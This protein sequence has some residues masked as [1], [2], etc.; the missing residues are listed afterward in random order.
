MKLRE[1]EA[2][3]ILEEVKLNIKSGI[4][5]ASLQSEDAL[6]YG[7]DGLTPKREPIVSLLRSIQAL[8]AE[9]LDVG[10]EFFSISSVFQKPSLIKEISDLLGL[11]K[12][13]N[14]LLRWE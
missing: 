13:T 9:G 14:Q 4:N 2:K 5:G 1:H 11:A 6:L 7:S 12:K 10:F 3:K 8:G